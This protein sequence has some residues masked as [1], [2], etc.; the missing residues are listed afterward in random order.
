MSVPHPGVRVEPPTRADR[1]LLQRRLQRPHPL[2]RLRAEQGW[3]F[4]SCC[5]C[6]ELGQQAIWLLI[7]CT[8]LNNHSG[9]GSAH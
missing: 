6:Q 8:R 4:M 9:T 1:D 3:K 7:G 2:H 5:H